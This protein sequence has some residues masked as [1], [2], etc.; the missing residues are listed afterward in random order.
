MPITKATPLGQSEKISVKFDMNRV[1]KFRRTMY[2][3]NNSPK[4]TSKIRVKG[5]IT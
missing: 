2:I 5:L 1:G 4:E 3:E